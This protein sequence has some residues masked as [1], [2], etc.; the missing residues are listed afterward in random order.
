MILLL[1][2]KTTSSNFSIRDEG[3]INIGPAFITSALVFGRVE[4]SAAP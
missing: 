4:P 1:I 3:G 2:G